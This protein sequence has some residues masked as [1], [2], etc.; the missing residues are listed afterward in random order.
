MHLFFYVIAFVL[1]FAAPPV[2]IILF[3]LTLLHE[4]D[5]GEQSSLKSKR[6]KDDFINH[7]NNLKL[8]D[9]KMMDVAVPANLK[10]GL[11]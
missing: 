7:M 1:C 6:K 8:S 10:L 9:P 4:T 2:G 3:L 5:T 11:E